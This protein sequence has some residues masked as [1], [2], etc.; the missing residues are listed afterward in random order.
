MPQTETESPEVFE[1]VRRAPGAGASRERCEECGYA[2]R[3]LPKDQPCPECGH[4]QLP[5]A[6]TRWRRPDL[7]WHRSLAAGLVLLLS[8]TVYAV[9]SVLVQPFTDEVAGTLPA[10]NLPGPKLWAVPLL[11]RPIG[12]TPEMAGMVGTRTALLSLLGVWLVTAR[13][14]HDDEAEP[15]GGNDAG[16]GGWVRPATRWASIAL[17]GI[18]F[19]LLLTSQGFWP[20][21]LPP[22][23][24]VLVAGVELPAALLLYAHLR[25]LACRVPGRD[26]R[27]LFDLLRWMVPA[28]VAGGAILFSIDTLRDDAPF[29]KH[30]GNRF[31]IAAAY[32]V[33][34]V[35]CGI[36]ATAAVGSLALTFCGAAL[37]DAWRLLSGSRRFV[38]ASYR[39][40]ATAG[41][42]RVRFG[43]VAAGLVLLV[44]VA[45]PGNDRVLWFNAR[46]GLGGNLPF[47]NFPGPKLFAAAAVPEL[48]QEQ[49]WHPIVS[50]TLLVALNV[51]AIWLLTTRLD[52]RE[53]WVLR[54][55]VRWLPV[56]SVGAALGVAGAWR[57]S[58]PPSY[59]AYFVNPLNGPLRSEFFASVTVLCELPVTVLIYAY[60][61]R[62]AARYVGDG[63]LRPRLFRVAVVIPV[64]VMMSFMAFLHSREFRAQR[65]S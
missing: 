41:G 17:F 51:A 20:A 25:N 63:S 16:A 54:G 1:K 18:A 59:S 7:A 58:V 26:R 12:R 11:Q 29:L 45:V 35:T 24:L 49:Y 64:L 53:G 39:W 14:E 4:R 56:A 15:T 61:S 47:Y 42:L 19:G 27:R 13:K 10:L 48:G 33:A 46:V 30:A 60:L 34:A 36:I 37:P 40:L 57:A 44:L 52:G 8:V 22:Y 55:L 23:R 21:E 38:R 6:A 65:G 62:L 31:A 9:S 28:V 3:G 5:A 50:R 2:L 32:G 43:C